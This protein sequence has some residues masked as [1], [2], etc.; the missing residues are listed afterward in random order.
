MRRTKNI[1]IAVSNGTYRKARVW[2]AKHN[3]S[4]SAMV[5]YLLDYLPAVVQ[6][7]HELRKQYPDFETRGRTAE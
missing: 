2:T 5:E 1:T 7:I 6:A 4:V 3:T